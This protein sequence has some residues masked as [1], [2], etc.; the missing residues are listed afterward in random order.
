MTKKT[1]IN[2]FLDKHSITDKNKVV[3]STNNNIID[4]VKKDARFENFKGRINVYTNNYLLLTAGRFIS[5]LRVKDN[6]IIENDYEFSI[7]NTRLVSSRGLLANCD[8]KSSNPISSEVDQPYLD[9]IAK[10]VTI[11]Q[12]TMDPDMYKPK[13]PQRI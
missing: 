5:E 13:G 2:K 4:D 12:K 1:K 11:E 10:Q 6:K 7:A 9:S 8:I 3:V